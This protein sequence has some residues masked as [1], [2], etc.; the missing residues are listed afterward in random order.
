MGYSLHI[1]IAL[2]LL[3]LA[4]KACAPRADLRVWPEIS[5]VGTNTTVYLATTRAQI[6]DGLWSASQRST[7]N[8]AQID[9][10]VPPQHRPGRVELPSATT[11]N[12]NT[13]FLAVDIEPLAY[14]AFYRLVPNSSEVARELIVT[15]HGFNNTLAD[16]VFRTAQ[17]VH[18]LDIQGSVVHYSWPSLG[19][20]LGYAA[21]RDSALF[22]R[23]GLE[24]LLRDLARAGQRRIV[25]VAHSMG[26]LL[27][28]ETLRRIAAS[29][30]RSTLDNIA[31]VVLMAPDIDIGLFRQQ[32]NTIGQIPQPFVIFT[33]QRD[34][35]LELSA[36]LT[37]Q[38]NRLGNIP[39]VEAVEGLDVT[40]IDLTNAPDVDVR[41]QAALSSPSVLRFMEQSAELR[42]SMQADRAGRT[43]FVP[44]AV[45]IAR[46]ATTI[47]LAPIVAKEVTK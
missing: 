43:G 24:L 35:A 38:P 27:T 6:E 36:R 18:D 9:V 7:L 40:V 3:T 37:G 22:A 31:G 33:S 39:G 21:D 19:R 47:M 1:R 17:M 14:Q 30:D 10:S 44:G 4:L 46:E 12:P 32:V 5:S 26:A 42:R 23:D 34:P 13:D 2:L 8:F 28:M 11:A 25:L 20:P 41:H 15:V 29:S 16:G 45:L